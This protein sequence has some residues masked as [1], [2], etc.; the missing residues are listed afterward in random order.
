MK[1]A[2]W[3]TLFAVL[4]FVGIVVARLPASW[5]APGSSSAITCAD[6]DGTVWNGTCT[7]LSAYR[8]PVGDLAWEVHPLRLLAG[9][10]NV[11]VVL[12]R[13]S[14]SAR[15]IVEVGTSRNITAR[16]VHADLTVDPA[17]MSQFP[18]QIRAS[19][20]HA[21]VPLLRLKGQVIKVLQ[22]E[23]EIHDLEMG[24]VGAA[25]L[26]GS[27]SLSFPPGASSDPIGR[28]HDLGGPLAVEGSLRLTPEP[29]LNV[30]GMV[31]ARATASPQLQQDLQILGS[32]DAQGRRL[33]SFA[34]TF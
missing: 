10:L 25:Q 19:S 15:G 27:Y 12:T 17:L 20:I 6:V 3:L 8:Q 13:G 30:E 33:F 14:G 31:G 5:V 7:G 24:P 29:G 22:G 26:L 32:P 23:I 18:G 21:D 1:R 9:K 16:D 34:S 2:V 4:A 28:L 11:S